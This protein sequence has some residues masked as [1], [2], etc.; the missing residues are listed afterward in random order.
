[1]QHIAELHEGHASAA[2]AGE[3]RGATMTVRIPVTQPE[4]LPPVPDES[5]S[6]EAAGGDE[7]SVRG[8]DVLVVEDDPDAREM[9]RIVLEDRGAAVRS[10][11]DFDAALAV[12]RE[13]WPDVLVCDI[14]LPGRDG[15][16]LIREVRTLQP[17]GAPRLAAVA[18]TAFARAEDRDKA[19][20]AGFDLHLAKPFKPHL[21][22]AALALLLGGAPA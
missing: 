20:A 22:M 15:Y 21:L 2:S 16:E 19:L 9:L 8:R 1:V 12:L 6:S 11:A 5:G 4:Q 10:A 17:A 14:G 13:H 3:G 18:L 7:P